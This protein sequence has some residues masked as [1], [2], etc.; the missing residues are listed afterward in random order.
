MLKKKKSNPQ[1]VILTLCAIKIKGGIGRSRKN[2][3]K[4]QFSG[5]T[6]GNSGQFKK[7]Q[8]AWSIQHDSSFP[9]LESQVK[10]N[11]WPSNTT[12]SRL[13]LCFIPQLSKD[14]SLTHPYE[15][16]WS[17]R[18]DV[19]NR[20][21]LLWQSQTPHLHCLDCVNLLQIWGTFSCCRTRKWPWK[22][23]RD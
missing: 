17:L 16:K 14:A 4:L 8:L 20:W 3:L 7:R 22:W 2:V 13:C 15:E 1:A 11:P 12:H 21:Q 23:S 5:S 19:T 9:G 6:S 18:S 10:S